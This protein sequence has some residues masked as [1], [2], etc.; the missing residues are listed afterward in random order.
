M[1]EQYAKFSVPDAV[2]I[3][4]ELQQSD[5][6]ATDLTMYEMDALDIVLAYCEAQV[7]GPGE[8]L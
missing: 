7:D 2:A 8:G 5:I 3:L 1:S 4:R 6:Y